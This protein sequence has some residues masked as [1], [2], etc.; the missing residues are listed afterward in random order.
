MG[1]TCLAW[2]YLY[3][4]GCFLECSGCVWS[5]YLG[6]GELDYF[7]K[8]TADHHHA[9]ERLILIRWRHL[10]SEQL[11]LQCSLEGPPMHVLFHASA[12][13]RMLQQWSL[14]EPERGSA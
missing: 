3:L 7:A 13:C 5:T 11:S 9:H 2:T 4:T 6:D 12:S 1:A 10:P 8:G 14:G